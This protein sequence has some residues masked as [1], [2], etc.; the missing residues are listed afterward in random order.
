M[1]YDQVVRIISICSTAIDPKEHSNIL[2]SAVV[3]K[4]YLH[5]KVR[6]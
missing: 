6:K 2:L 5:D 4:G 3:K 1:A